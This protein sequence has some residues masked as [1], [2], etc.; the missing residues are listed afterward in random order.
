[1]TAADPIVPEQVGV[2][3]GHL[4]GGQATLWLTIDGVIYGISGQCAL[5]IAA[6]LVAHV[7]VSRADAN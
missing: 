6:A 3:H 1:M 7:A 2:A 4:D 5:D